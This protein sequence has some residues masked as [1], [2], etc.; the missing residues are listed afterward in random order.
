MITTVPVGTEVEA[1]GA[2]DEFCGAEVA[3]GVILAAD[4][5]AVS[6]ASASVLRSLVEGALKRAVWVGWIWKGEFCD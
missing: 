6:G 5:A 2:F 4:A 1:T 3:V